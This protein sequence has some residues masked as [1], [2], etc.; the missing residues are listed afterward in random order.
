METELSIQE[1][2]FKAYVDLETEELTNFCREIASTQADRKGTMQ[3][4]M[5]LKE[6]VHK[7]V[8]VLN[9]AHALFLAVDAM[10][11]KTCH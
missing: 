9:E 2:S 10:R 6:Y 1:K 11:S 4:L 5:L 3:V 7:R 8:E